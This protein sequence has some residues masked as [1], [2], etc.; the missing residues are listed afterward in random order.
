MESAE[1]NDIIKLIDNSEL[2]SLSPMSKVCIQNI[3]YECF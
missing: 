1:K 3:I 2:K